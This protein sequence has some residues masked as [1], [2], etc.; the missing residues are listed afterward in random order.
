MQGESGFGGR[1]RGRAARYGC[2][3]WVV[4]S[5]AVVLVT[6]CVVETGL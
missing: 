3:S 2:P 4:E 5:P 6:I 1:G